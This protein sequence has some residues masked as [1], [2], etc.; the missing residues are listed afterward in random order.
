MIDVK[1]QFKFLSSIT[2]LYAAADPNNIFPESKE[3]CQKLQTEF[4]KVRSTNE[5]CIMIS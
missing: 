1:S 5:L 3:K 4:L 2:D